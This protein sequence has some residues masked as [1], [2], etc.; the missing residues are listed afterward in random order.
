MGSSYLAVLRLPRARPL[1]VASLVGRLSTATGPLSVVLFVQDQTGSLALAGA[2]SAA[3]A[4]ASGLL[5]PVRGRLVD[6]YG[7]RRCLPAM[8]VAFAAALA[9]MVAVTR[10][11]PATVPA[12]VGLAAAAGRYRVAS[13]PASS[14]PVTNSSSSRTASS[15]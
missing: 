3:I 7:Q 13:A 10:P 15:A 9:G 2:S 14:G 4:L 6:R 12:T 11:G 8:A 5:A 1:L